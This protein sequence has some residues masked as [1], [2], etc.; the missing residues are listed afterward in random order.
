MPRQEIRSYDYVNH[1]YAKVRE[2]LIADPG[3]IFRAATRTAAVRARSVAAELRLT[4]AGVDV[5]AE[6]IV[7]IGA[8][9]DEAGLLGGP[10]TR[11]PV[12]W[13]AAK[14]PQLFPLMSA[15]LTVYPLTATETQLDFLGHYDPP[16]GV[17]GGAMDALVGHRIAE[18]SVHRLIGDVARHLRE[19]LVQG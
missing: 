11:I 18:A 1:P 14:H 19:Q 5:A 7:S 10:L 6:V 3:E 16:L 9:T 8:I 17:V 2:A 13:E 12:S 15:E 4:I